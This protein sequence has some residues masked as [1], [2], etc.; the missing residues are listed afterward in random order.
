MGVVSPVF[1]RWLSILGLAYLLLIFP[2]GELL[3]VHTQG[4]ASE[5]RRDEFNWLYQWATS[6]GRP[7]SCF[8]LSILLVGRLSEWQEPE[9]L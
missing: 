6:G 9:I 3:L 8:E 4:T 2:V 1:I 5:C 7:L